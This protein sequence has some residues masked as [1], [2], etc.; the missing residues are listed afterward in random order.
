MAL[1]SGQNISSASDKW[2]HLEEELFPVHKT[3]HI[4]ISEVLDIIVEVVSKLACDVS[5]RCITT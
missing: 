1:P 3:S 4:V 5:A 2:P